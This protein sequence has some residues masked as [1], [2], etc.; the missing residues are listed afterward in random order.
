MSKKNK[1][2]IDTSKIFPDLSPQD[3]AKNKGKPFIDYDLIAVHCSIEIH[4]DAKTSPVSFFAKQVP[5]NTEA[6][7]NYRI[8]KISD[9]Y[10]YGSGHVAI[11][12][13]KCSLCE[14]SGIAMIY[15]HKKTVH[16]L[17]SCPD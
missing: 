1:M 2:S 16:D 6:V 8:I 14:M 13:A 9:A 4:Q 15:N 12:F 3:Y 5:D 11:N 17:P 10:G 7:A